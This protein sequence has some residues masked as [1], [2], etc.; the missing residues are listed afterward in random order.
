MWRNHRLVNTLHWKSTKLE[1][2]RALK[3]VMGVGGFL[4]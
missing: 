2:T 4:L 1:T 3:R